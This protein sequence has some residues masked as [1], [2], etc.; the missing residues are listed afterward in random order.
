MGERMSCFAP[1]H[2]HTCDVMSVELP[3]GG[4]G[5]ST[6]A[7]LWVRL[8]APG[9]AAVDAVHVEGQALHVLSGEW[10]TSVQIDS[11]QPHDWQ[12]P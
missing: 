3:R 4:W 5:T 10:P 11:N 1:A 6:T 8:W 9:A 12:L 2:P 7:V